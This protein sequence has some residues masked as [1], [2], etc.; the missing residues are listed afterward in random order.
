MKY[1]LALMLVANG[2]IE[3]A[4]SLSEQVQ[5]VRNVHSKNEYY[6]KPVYSVNHINDIDL[7]TSKGKGLA[8]AIITAAL[9]L[10]RSNNNADFRLHISCCQNQFIVK[11]SLYPDSFYPKSACS[12]CDITQLKGDIIKEN[13]A[14]R[15]FEKSR[16]ARNPIDF[17]I[18]P[19][20]HVVNYKDTCFTPD[21]FINQL[22]MAQEL[23]KKLTHSDLNLYVN[24]GINAGQTVLHSH[25]HFCTT[26]Q[27]IKN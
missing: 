27:W 8:K 23:S 25:M 18:V 7:S 24:N 19:R 20:I 1:F 2:L 16:P 26:A 6:I 13:K 11:I 15:A 9:D 22:A 17:L 3:C 12:F 4:S 5:V 14:V 10:S 21:I